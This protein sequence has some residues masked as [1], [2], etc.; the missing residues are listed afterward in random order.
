MSFS[1]RYVR[2]LALVFLFSTTML[3]N[4][5][6]QIEVEQFGDSLL[7]SSSAF[8]IEG[9]GNIFSSQ[10]IGGIASGLDLEFLAYRERFRSDITAV[11]WDHSF[12]GSELCEQRPGRDDW[13]VLINCPTEG[14][15]RLYLILEFA[16]GTQEFYSGLA[17]VLA[18]PTEAPPEEEGPAP[19]SGEQLYELSCAGCHNPGPTSTKRRANMTATVIGNAINRIGQMN[20]LTGT[21]QAD[22]EAI[23]AYLRQ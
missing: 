11:Y 13:H 9:D 1:N 16:D 17:Q 10:G 2:S 8:E 15:L 14:A 22:L 19:L 21:S 18:T 7:A 23:A 6:S 5:C 4:N 20:F 12:N 3:Y